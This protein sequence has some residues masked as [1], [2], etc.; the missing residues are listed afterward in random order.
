MEKNKI[1]ISFFLL[2]LFSNIFALNIE[3]VSE[4]HDLISHEVVL[5]INN[6][7]DKSVF[8]SWDVNFYD[9]VGGDIKNFLVEYGVEKQRDVFVGAIVKI[10]CDQSKI[11]CETVVDSNTLLSYDV[12][13]C[14]ENG[15]VCQSSDSSL[16]GAKQPFDNSN[17]MCFEEVIR[18]SFVGTEKYID[19]SN[20]NDK[21][22]L[23]KR[24]SKVS[25][26]EKNLKSLKKD[27]KIAYSLPSKFF[28]KNQSKFVRLSWDTPL[29]GGVWGS[30][31]Y[32]AMNPI[33]WWDAN[34]D[35]RQR[36]ELNTEGILSSDVTNEHAI[37]VHV[38]SS[39]TDFWEN[40]QSNGEDVRFTNSDNSIDLNYHF[41]IDTDNNDLWAWVRVPEFDAD[42]NTIINMYYG[43]ENAVDNQN[44]E[45]T[46]SSD[47]SAVYHLDEETGGVAEDSTNNYD[48]SIH[49]LTLNQ[50]GVINTSF[51]FT[52][53]ESTRV[54]TIPAGD[55]PSYGSFSLWVYN[56][57]SA[58]YYYYTN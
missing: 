54:N 53:S 46:Y 30:S 25:V 9:F 40:I 45:G 31:G 2:M 22:L 23:E 44:E 29:D 24:I 7:E 42:A 34:W 17:F 27:D 35:Y 37:L 4:K 48:G 13:T 41:E 32:W 51:L 49:G 47:Y 36:L 52:E 38:D 57:S 11:V 3:V 33:S 18:K 39:N 20:P 21:H 58:G 1:L 28:S 43:N 10:D 8:K 50:S 55:I 6:D 15:Y 26:E 14:G 12:C 16:I 19:Y 5:K 56:D